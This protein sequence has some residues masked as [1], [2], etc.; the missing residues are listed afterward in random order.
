MPILLLLQLLSSFLIHGENHNMHTCIDAPNFA[1]GFVELLQLGVLAG[2][3]EP[4]AQK[5]ELGTVPESFLL[6]PLSN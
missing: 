4:S 5:W 6:P 3:F 1:C 2:S